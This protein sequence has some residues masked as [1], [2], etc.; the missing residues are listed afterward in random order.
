MARQE[1]AIRLLVNGSLDTKTNPKL[2]A[3][4]SL[5][6][7]Q[8]MY[9]LRTGEMRPRNGFTKR[10][11][12]ATLNI[13]GGSNLFPTLSGGL[14]TIA[15]GWRSNAAPW[16]V[17][18]K[19]GNITDSASRAGWATASAGSTISSAYPWVTSRVTGVRSA[20]DFFG[21]TTPADMVDPD[22]AATNKSIRGVVFTDDTGDYPL[23]DAAELG[24]ERPQM[25]A[26]NL[27]SSFVTM[28][29]GASAKT[30]S[31]GTGSHICVFGQTATNTLLAAR[32][33]ASGVFIANTTIATDMDSS[34]FFDVKPIPGAA[35]IAVAY[36]VT[37]AGG[38]KCGI[39]DPSAGTF[40]SVVTTA[41]ADANQC[42][43]WLNDA[44][45]T[46]NMYLATAGTTA[47]IVVRTMSATTMVVSATNTIDATATA[48]VRNVTGHI[49]TGA[50]NYIV[51]WDIAGSSA[52]Y[53]R[54]RVG[55]WTGSA[56]VRDHYGN[57]SLYSRSFALDDGRYYVLGCLSSTVQPLYTLV[58]LDGIGA[59]VAASARG[60]HACVSLSGEGGVRR[61]PCTLATA[62][63]YSSTV[64]VPAMRRRK[65]STPDGGSAQQR[66]SVSLL[67]FSTM[68]K[69]THA[70]ELGGTVFLPGGVVN[71]DDGPNVDAATW[72]IYPE[73]PT[74][75]AA[76]GGSMTSSGA[77]LYRVVFKTY[78]AAN[79]AIR[80]AS[81]IPYAITLGG[82][83]TQVTL[84]CFNLKAIRGDYHPSASVPGGVLFS[85]IY[86]RGP[87]ATGA[88]LYNK[89][90]EFAMNV[91]G[92]GDTFNFVD[93]MSD[94]NAAL[95]EVAYFNGN[96]LEN[97]N[98]PST[99]LLEVNGNRVG[100]VSAEDPTE[101]W[102]SKEYKAGAGIGFN[103]LLKVSITGDGAGDLTA[104]A[105]M[106]GRWV[107]FKRTAIYVLS[108]DG[109]NDLGQ[110][111]FNAPQAVSRTLGTINPS[112]V[113]ETPDGIMF[114]CAD[115]DFWLLDRNLSL[116][117]IGAPVQEYTRNLPQR[118][119]GAAL[120]T[121]GPL[122][123]FVLSG[124]SAPMLEWDYYHK[125]WSTHILPGVDL[126][127]AVDCANSSVFGWCYL[128]ENGD[129]LAESPGAVADTY[130]G[131]LPIIP[132]VSFPHL[133]LAGL[134]GYQRLH[135]IEFTLAALGNHTL[136]V[137][138][139][140]D[141][142]G[143][144]SG[145]A[146]T[147]ALVSSGQT[148]QVEY[149]PP[150]GRAKCTS[151]RPV[152]TVTGSPTSGTFVLTGA[153]A[154]ITVKRGTVVHAADRMT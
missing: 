124:E 81:S 130:N 79:R 85:E 71:L 5:L 34:G 22:L 33:D 47:G 51:L 110:G 104:L 3:P 103:P 24:T 25:N 105:A 90:G 154:Y 40:T 70:R 8:N 99:K 144:L 122:V 64:I 80:S 29:A 123:R 141:L 50:T 117:P 31:T 127:N 84:T 19:L 72:P 78:D 139:E 1:K 58:S 53:D 132:V 37:A 49:N 149:N 134:A 32:F 142:E 100:L 60:S 55:F 77:Y 45:S 16:P 140:Y 115:G 44:L 18:L 102:F 20:Q 87:S 92:G 42:M 2:V 17:A 35:T 12:G 129:L 126:R 41:G 138:A 43:G 75:A 76:G 4:G 14:G 88:T 10:I 152:L 96:V 56:S 143:S 97:L 125:R 73:T 48:S 112:S 119:G 148:S 30:A 62:I 128:L 6:E 36:R 94:A 95:G 26:L 74:G 63:T 46:G 89:V 147:I 28:V 116:Q 113:I 66:A 108:G 135:A 114:Q 68:R 39:F 145:P 106:D 59:G 27:S 82:G 101:F 23:S 111:S 137:D 83:D 153:T 120:V 11:D 98:P 15:T 52:I 21:T 91:T 146:K 57:H 151:V 133:Q 7:L 65:I 131:T 38:V 109:P 121:A 13:T 61:R 93:T 9:Q 150:D 136:S 86:R 69:V 67:T 54:I 107:L 118:V